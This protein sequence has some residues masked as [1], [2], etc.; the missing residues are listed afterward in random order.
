MEANWLASWQVAILK[1]NCTPHLPPPECEDPRLTCWEEAMLVSF[2]FSSAMTLPT[3][4]VVPVEAGTGSRD[5][6]L[7]SP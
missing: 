5:D 3:A 6:V 7:G 4:L 1:G 2:L